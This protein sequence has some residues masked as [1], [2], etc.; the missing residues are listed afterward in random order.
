MN[1][2]HLPTM[3]DILDDH[4]DICARF[5]V[6]FSSSKVGVEYILVGAKTKEKK[7]QEP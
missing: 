4:G 7:P 1:K 2:Q 6:V 3:T 5:A